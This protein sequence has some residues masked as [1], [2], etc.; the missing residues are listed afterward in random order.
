MVKRQSVLI[1]C[2]AA[3]VCAAAVASSEAFVSPRANNLTFSGAVALPGVVL[4]A[5]SYTFEVVEPGVGN[6]TVRVWSRDHRRVFFTGL[7][8]QVSRPR[9]MDP[10][11][12]I[13]LGESVHGEAPPIHVWYPIGDS[14]GREFLYTR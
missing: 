6:S 1:A 8:L 2:V 9:G 13:L 14:M 10:N 12:T 11:R 3:V 4:P 5:G 7:T